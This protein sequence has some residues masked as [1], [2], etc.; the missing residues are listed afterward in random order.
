MYLPASIYQTSRLII[1]NRTLDNTGLFLATEQITEDAGNVLTYNQA[2]NTNVNGGYQPYSNRYGS[3]TYANPGDNGDDSPDSESGP[4]LAEA[5]RAALPDS[6]ISGRRPDPATRVGDIEMNPVGAQGHAHGDAS[7]PLMSAD[8]VENTPRLGPLPEVRVELDTPSAA[9]TS[10][11][12][13]RPAPVAALGSGE[14]STSTIT[15]SSVATH[16]YRNGQ[17]GTANTN[18][19]GGVGGASGWS[20]EQDARMRDI[21]SAS[22]Q[23]A[24]AQGES[25]GGKIEPPPT[26]SSSSPDKPATNTTRTLPDVAVNDAQKAGDADEEDAMETVDLSDTKGKGK[27]KAK[28]SQPTGTGLGVLMGTS[29]GADAVDQLLGEWTTTVR[30]S[31]G[32]GTSAAGIEG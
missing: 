18:P 3:S 7:R 8:A 2:S 5:F 14:T 6:L 32:P 11:S 23:A 17:Q 31:A 13:S 29:N 4:T 1:A 21:L 30:I 25:E 27:G 26:T 19:A 28:A 22:V 16:E 12:I 10:A 15:S 9:S 20:P 24:I